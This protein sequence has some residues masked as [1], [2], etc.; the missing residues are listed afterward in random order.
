MLGEIRLCS[1][2]VQAVSFLCAIKI[3]LIMVPKK[4]L[5]Q[6]FLLSKEVVDD[7]I[8]AGEVSAVD[9]VLE[10]G[11]G[12]GVLTEALLQKAGR[13]IAVE[14][15]DLLIP[16][17]QKKFV[18]EISSGRLNLINGDILKIRNLKSEISGYK[19]IANIPYYI[20]GAIIKLLLTSKHL[21]E[22][23]VLLVQKE[24][25]ERIVACDG[26]ESILSISVKVFGMPTI[27]REVPRNLFY[28]EPAVDS[29]L[30]KIANIHNPFKNEAEEKS[31][32]SLVKSGFSAKRKL[33]LNNLSNTHF[34]KKE[35][36]KIFLD[37]GID[38]KTRA[39]DVPLETWK[40]IALFRN[41]ERFELP[42]TG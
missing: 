29:V 26:K 6:H 38:E 37:L 10:I 13:V 3:Y 14:K 40:Q 21:P 15:D 2:G 30:L 11:P 24:V 25:G 5:G 27:V 20:T 42:A 16:K 36:V 9:S 7:A 31:F 18:S 23:I 4:S 35:L 8:V 28:P 33:L 17:L 34:S 39:E 12:N 32:F 41:I 22:I 1:S 19:V